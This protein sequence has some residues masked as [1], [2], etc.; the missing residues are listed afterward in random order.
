[1]PPLI[2]INQPLKLTIISIKCKRA[3]Y[4]TYN[5][6]QIVEV[7]IWSDDDCFFDG[8]RLKGASF[9]LGDETT[10]SMKN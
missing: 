3:Q 7:V 5:L 1:M 8:V 9:I 4:T 10:N 2:A 6:C